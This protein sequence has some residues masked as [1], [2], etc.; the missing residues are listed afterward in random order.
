M[1][2]RSIRIT[3]RSFREF[4][5]TEFDEEA[6]DNASLAAEAILEL[7][8]L[9][10]GTPHLTERYQRMTHEIY[11]AIRTTAEAFIASPVSPKPYTS[12]QPRAADHYRDLRRRL[13]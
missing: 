13:L 11:A 3:V 1:L 8:N 9:K 12:K 6:F 5:D 2:R 4:T 7:F 10:S